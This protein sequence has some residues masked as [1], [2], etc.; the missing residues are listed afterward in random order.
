MASEIPLSLVVHF[1]RARS[2]VVEGD[3]GLRHDR[4]DVTI[5]IWV[6]QRRIKYNELARARVGDERGV[7]LTLAPTIIRSY[8]LGLP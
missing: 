8:G 2:K 3:G 6:E 1:L 4:Y 7:R 5:K